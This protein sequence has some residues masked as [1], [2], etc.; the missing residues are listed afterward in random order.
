[1]RA[2]DALVRALAAGGAR[3]VFTL[4]GN[5]IMS[6]F[7]AAVGAPVELIHVRHEAA[8]VH[9]ADA[10]GRLSGRPGVALV[11]AGPGFANTVS[12][13]YAARCAESPLV[14]LSGAAPSGRTGA[15][16]F[17]EMD[18]AGVAAAVSKASWTCAAPERLAG[19]FARA[20]RLAMAG[21]PGPVHVAV[22]VDV[23]ESVAQ[24]GGAPAVEPAVEPGAEC[25]AGSGGEGRAPAPVD[26]DAD[27]PDAGE[28]D[29]ARLDAACRAVGAAARPLVLAGPPY[30]R[31]H[32]A[33]VMRRLR[34]A[35]VAAA[36]MDSPRGLR[37]PALGALAEAV[38][39]ADLIVLLGK[40]LD[41]TLELGAAPPFAPDC[42]FVQIDPEAA[43][44]RQ[45]AGNAGGR[46]ALQAQGDPARWAAAMA[47]RLAG[48]GMDAGWRAEVEA[49]VAY[50]P[51][52][53]RSAGGDAPVHPA[54]LGYAVH[55]FLA[56][57]AESVFV[58]D[59][60]EIGQWA[61]AC[62]SAPHR[63]INGPAGAIGAALPFALAAR[64]LFPGARIAA[65]LGDGT[66]GFHALEID[67]AVRYGLPF[68]AVIGNDARWNAE[69]QVQRRNYG[70]GRAFGCELRASRYDGVARA[71]DAYGA[72]VESA[73]ALPAALEAA[74]ASGLP[75]CVNVR[76]Q[77]VAAPVIARG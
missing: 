28:P 24:A 17:Q 63:I 8:A 72:A 44:L 45:A 11:T 52:H 20:R 73:A 55:D 69:V 77:P 9:A 10:I 71:L 56:G 37:D 29:A 26:L 65:A 19:D 15:G 21:R 61:Q 40:R 27:G 4:S 33:G 43:A 74:H 39:Q 5:Q 57:A 12:A 7:D 25:A 46:M 34:G 60:G 48:C 31:R 54:R 70:A 32:A 66:F 51:A 53:W 42:R 59:G 1:M 3:R 64:T 18:Q 38:A 13:L 22:P 14:L 41:H 50:R 58:S 62:V 67:T 35:G 49:A 47:E 75:A 30:R 16:A 68:V 2:A 23:L 76:L 6:V 36:A